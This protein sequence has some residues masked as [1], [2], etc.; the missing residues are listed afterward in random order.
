[1]LGGT[2]VAL[3]NLKP[4]SVT[5]CLG[6]TSFL[7]NAFRRLPVVVVVQAAQHWARCELAV[8]RRCIWSFWSA[9]DVLLNPLMRSSVVKVLRV[10]LHDSVQM[11]LAQD[12]D[13]VEALAPQ[14][15]EEA[16]AY[17]VRLRCFVWCFQHLNA[18]GH[19]LER[20]SI[21][22]VV[23]PDQ[24]SRS[25][26]GVASRSCWATHRSAGFLVTLKCTTRREPS[27]IMTNTNTVR[28][29]MSYV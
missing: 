5:G 4:A 24:V 8:D 20:I 18:C 14:A 10:L 2:E 12:Q 13:V 3:K 7:P 21:L 6:L 17:G 16:L 9:R 26:Y 19:S 28:K 23:V 25:P 22:V 15:A 29:K 1:V 27:S 11:P